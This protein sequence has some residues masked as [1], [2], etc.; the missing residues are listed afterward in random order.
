MMMM[1]M[2]M[3]MMGAMTATTRS[4]A[5]MPVQQIRHWTIQQQIPL[6][7]YFVFV[8]A[9]VLDDNQQRNALHQLAAT[10]NAQLK[11]KSA[12]LASQTIIWRSLHAKLASQ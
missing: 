3:M 10:S 12:P 9:G 4:A 2:M 11:P 8:Y 7:V 5:H 6:F 1:M